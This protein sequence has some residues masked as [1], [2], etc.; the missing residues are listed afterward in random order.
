V[1]IGADDVRMGTA[2]ATGF[3]PQQP[4]RAANA[5]PEL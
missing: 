3:V 5:A 4:V 1:Q 2:E